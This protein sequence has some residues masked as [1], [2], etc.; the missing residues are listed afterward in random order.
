MATK[1]DSIIKIQ[2]QIKQNSQGIQDY[3]SDLTQW[4]NDVGK[5][6]VQTK[7]VEQAPQKKQVRSISRLKN[8][9]ECQ[10]APA[11]QKQSRYLRIVKGCERQ[12]PL[13]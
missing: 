3:L 13:E 9:L 5:K 11:N 6:E 12:I 4:T 2:Q 10:A 1:P 7:K 8:I